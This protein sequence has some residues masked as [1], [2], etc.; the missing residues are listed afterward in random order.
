MKFELSGCFWAFTSLGLHFKDNHLVYFAHNEDFRGALETRQGVHTKLNLFGFA[1][2]MSFPG[3][4]LFSW[5]LW[6]PEV[7]THF[8]LDKAIKTRKLCKWFSI[9][10]K[11]PELWK[12][13]PLL[14][15]LWCC[16][17]KPLSMD[18]NCWWNRIIHQLQRSQR[19]W[20]YNRGV[21]LQ[22]QLTCSRSVEDWRLTTPYVCYHNTRRSARW[23]K[24][25][26]EDHRENHSD[27]CLKQ[28]QQR[29]PWLILTGNQIHNYPPFLLET[30]LNQMEGSLEKLGIPEVKSGISV[31]QRLR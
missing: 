10:F 27:E 30:G 7:T 1:A 16:W 13:L 21:P 17:S 8:C 2:S 14:S 9:F 12:L 26:W 24:N 31:C 15:P 23:P 28:L 25:L 6:Y 29:L 5:E 18:Q 11:S 19:K 3:N 22:S 20:Y 4:K